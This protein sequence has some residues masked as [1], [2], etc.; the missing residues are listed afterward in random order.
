MLV[1]I[2]FV[3]G[4]RIGRR[5]MNKLVARAILPRPLEP[6]NGIA[7]PVDAIAKENVAPKEVDPMLRDRR[8]F[9][10]RASEPFRLFLQEKASSRIALSGRRIETARRPLYEVSL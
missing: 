10:N 3:N 4:L 1:T 8:C 7:M 9:F 5:I 2:E 6:G